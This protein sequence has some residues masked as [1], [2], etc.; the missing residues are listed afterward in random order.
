M[1]G[2]LGG[3]LPSVESSGLGGGPCGG[4]LLLHP[5]SWLAARIAIKINDASLMHSFLNKEVKAGGSC[6][7]AEF[8]KWLELIAE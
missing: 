4:V 1:R 7:P 6:P 5:V 2:P 8:E 3:G